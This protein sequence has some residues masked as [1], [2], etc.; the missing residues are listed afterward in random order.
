MSFNAAEKHLFYAELAKLLEAGFGIRKAADAM[1]DLPLPAGQ[2]EVLNTLH[3]GLEDGKTISDSLTGEIPSFTEF[4]CAIIAAG[5][6]GG[7]LGT[8]M[9]HL[10]DYFGMLDSARREALRAMLYPVVI[11]HIGVFI[12]TVPMSMIHGRNSISEMAGSFF[13]SLLGVY[14]VTI[15]LI[16]LVRALF[17]SA[18]HN[19]AADSFLNRIP[20]IGKTRRD[21]AMATFTKVA[22]TC[23]LAGLPM[24]ETL[25]M[26]CDASQSGRI[27]NAG[28]R[29]QATLA[30]GNPIGPALGAEAAFPRAFARAYATG[31]HAGTLDSDL[32]NW[33]ARFQNEAADGIRN[34]AA[35]L[36]RVLYAGILI[37]VGWRIISFFNGYY[38]ELL[39]QLQ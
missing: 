11:L 27:R 37:F 22:H 14:A 2:A 4:E 23:L 30:E 32:A 18:R 7:R 13:I 34:L 39:N 1:L 28:K 12:G 19:V 24:R 9:Q 6:R 35:V 31:E 29:L 21:L 20:L 5:E 15:I 36:P 26:A 8:A 17:R 25:D 38:S 3:Q 16:L 10:S 33:A